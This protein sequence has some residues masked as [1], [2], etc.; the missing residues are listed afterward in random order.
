MIVFCKARVPFLDKD[1]IDA[2]MDLNPD[3]K[4]IRKGEST[5]FLEK[6]VMRAAFDTP[7]EPFLPKEVAESGRRP[8]GA[9][10]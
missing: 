1:M 10:S 8:S 9:A 6:W 7:T 2:T 5:Q 4:M 3:F